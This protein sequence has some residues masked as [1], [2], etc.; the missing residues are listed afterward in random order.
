MSEQPQTGGDK[1]NLSK[2]ISLWGYLG[3][4][5]GAVFGASWLLMTGI[6]LD[7]AGG[8]MN[9]LLAFIA[10]FLVELPLVLAYYEA[11]PMIPLAGGELSYAYLSFGNFI[12]MLVGWFGVLVN[13]I[14]CA[15]EVLAITRMLSYLVPQIGQATPLYTVGG[16]PVTIVSILLGLLLVVGIGA[17]QYR[18]TKLSSKFSTINTAIIITLALICV[19]VGFLHFDIANMQPLQTKNTFEGTLSLLSMLPFSIAGW[20]TISKG[21]QE[22]SSGVSVKKIGLSVVISVAVAITMYILT[23]IVPTGLMPWQE[24]SGATAPFA[25]AMNRVGLPILG[26]LLLFAACLGVVGVY[27]A[28]FFGATRLLYSLGEYGLI[29]KSFTKLHSKYKTPTTAIF[30]VSLIAAVVLFFGQSLFVPLVNVAAVAYIV[31]WG[32]TLFSVIRLRSKYP[33]LNRPV[34]M[35]GGKPMMIYGSLVS[36]VL[37]FLM[38][39]P[40]SPAALN[41]PS[42]YILLVVLLLLGITLYFFRDKSMSEAERSELILGNISD[43]IDN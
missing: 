12:G 33:K 6:W 22:A 15:W 14:L 31:L 39:V 18:G 23:L 29:P 21:A 30:F 4:G 25:E 32:S 10:C 43:E 16:A 13:I 27:N 24:M 35:P 38:L 11:V 19:V 40:G 26:T 34:K 5:I 36:I 42:E 41:W 1:G 3:M 17:L 9:A 28:V 7:A 8:P 2:S 37:L 20:E